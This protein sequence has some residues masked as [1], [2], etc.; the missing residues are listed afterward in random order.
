MLVGL[1]ENTRRNLTSHSLV[2]VQTENNVMIAGV[3]VQ[4]QQHA[5]N[6]PRARPDTDRASAF[7]MR[8]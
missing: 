5:G 3:I 4:F 1:T 7:L 8:W 6:C 2:F